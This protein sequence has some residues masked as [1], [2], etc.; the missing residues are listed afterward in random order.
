MLQKYFTLVPLLGPIGGGLAT[1][2][3]LSSGGAVV[4][5]GGAASSAARTTSLEELVQLV[6]FLVEER[7]KDNIVF[8]RVLEVTTVVGVTTNP[9]AADAMLQLAILFCLLFSLY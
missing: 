9:D 1:G 7:G 3:V 4:A 5:A 2:A 6:L 8:I